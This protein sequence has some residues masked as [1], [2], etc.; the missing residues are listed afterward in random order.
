MLS[1]SKDN[2]G[3]HPTMGYIQNKKYEILLFFS[4]LCACS[5][6]GSS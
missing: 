6:C 1:G 3:K 5:E 2:S 4:I